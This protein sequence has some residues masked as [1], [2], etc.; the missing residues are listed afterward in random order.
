MPSGTLVTTPLPFPP[1]DTT[2]RNVPGGWLIREKLAVT[3]LA[4]FIVRTQ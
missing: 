4:A 2:I 1:R 3:D